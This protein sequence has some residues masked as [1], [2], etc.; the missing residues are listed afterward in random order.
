MYRSGHGRTVEDE[1][2]ALAAELLMP[3][4]II[5]SVSD[6]RFKQGG[7]T[8]SEVRRVGASDETQARYS[9]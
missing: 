6:R 4:R 5:R 3:R 8:S 9:E 7:R 2:D 1:A